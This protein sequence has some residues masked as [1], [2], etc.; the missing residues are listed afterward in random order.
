[1]GFSHFIIHTLN[2]LILELAFSRLDRCWELRKY[3]LGRSNAW[4]GS[5]CQIGHESRDEDFHWLNEWKKTNPL[6]MSSL[7][8]SWRHPLSPYFLNNNQ[9]M[10][11][12]ICTI[13][14]RSPALG[15]YRLI[16]IPTRKVGWGLYL[17]GWDKRGMRDRVRWERGKVWEWVNVSLWSPTSLCFIPARI[18][19]QGGGPR[20][21]IPQKNLRIVRI[22][23]FELS[24]EQRRRHLN[25]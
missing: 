4:E 8:A 22:D 23:P 24:E 5:E 6:D 18:D 2:Q 3:V 14:S 13:L 12:E 20:T 7:E 21:G 17:G 11:C 10:N 9:I 25:R 19:Q 1:M 16:V 15:S